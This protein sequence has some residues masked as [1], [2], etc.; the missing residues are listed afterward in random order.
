MVVA[1]VTGTMV[2]PVATT[3][4]GS[5]TNNVI[6][7]AGLGVTGAGDGTGVTYRDGTDDGVSTQAGD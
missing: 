6:A 5:E 1:I 2:V 4:E 3:I 7:E